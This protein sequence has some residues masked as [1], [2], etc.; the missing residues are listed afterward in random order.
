[1]PVKAYYRD[2]LALQQLETAL[3]IFFAG[4][5][6]ASVV[7]LAGAADEIFGKYLAADGKLSSLDE[8]KKAGAAI[9]L[10]LYGEAT[11]PEHIAR[12]ANRAKNSLKH[13]D[14]GDDRIVK[15]DL[16]QEATDMLSRAIDNYW[17][18]AQDLT[19]LMERFEREI[20]RA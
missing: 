9:Q 10:K 5:D 18:F 15:F 17:I 4:E 16:K 11:A 14:V 2:Q 12:R 6:Y 13:W 20:L 1:M 19:Q 3:S 8:L 7:T